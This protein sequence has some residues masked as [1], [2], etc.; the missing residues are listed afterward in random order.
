MSRQ[1]RRAAV[2][3]LACLSV[4]GGVSGEGTN[5]VNFQCWVRHTWVNYPMLQREAENLN[6]PIVG[7][8]KAGGL[9]GLIALGRFEQRQY[10]E[11]MF[12]SGRRATQTPWRA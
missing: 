12:S 6:G 11:R 9:K 7:A 4:C 1:F 10:D 3:M 8:E 2:L 5:A